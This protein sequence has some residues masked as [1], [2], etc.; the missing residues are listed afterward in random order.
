MD[1]PHCKAKDS[2]IGDG[3]NRSGSKRYQCK[4]CGKRHTPEPKERGYSK[5]FRLQAIRLYV[6]GMNIRRIARH[7]GV[8]PQSISNWVNAYVEEL[9]SAPTP[10]EVETV[11]LDELFTFIGD[12]KTKPTSSQP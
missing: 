3:K 4:V 2:L 12:K 6:D 5:E 1:C 9:P 7:L 8:S 11:E 10:E